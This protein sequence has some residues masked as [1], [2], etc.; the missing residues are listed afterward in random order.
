MGA[1]K[2]LDLSTRWEVSGQL[3]ALATSLLGKERYWI[4]RVG[5]RAG[6]NTVEKK[7]ISCPC[8]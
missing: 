5:P 4:G 3:Y 8:Q 1:W 7:K 6:L 2:Y